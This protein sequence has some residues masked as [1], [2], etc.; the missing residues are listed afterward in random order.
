MFAIFNTDNGN[1]ILT[2]LT[3]AQAD[4][5]MDSHAFDRDIKCVS[6]YE[7]EWAAWEA[8]KEAEAYIE[9]TR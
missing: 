8:D 7:E 3:A 6:I 5:Y 2:G 1:T 9:A 4:A